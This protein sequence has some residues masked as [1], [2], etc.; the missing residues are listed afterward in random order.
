MRAYTFECAGTSAEAKVYAEV[1]KTHMDAVI[2]RYTDLSALIAEAAGSGL[3]RYE[4]L[5]ADAQQAHPA[6]STSVVCEDW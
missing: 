6:P 2:N 3:R 4:Q 5:V 1:E